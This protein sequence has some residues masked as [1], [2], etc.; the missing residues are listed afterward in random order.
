MRETNFKKRTP[1]SF[2]WEGG[3]R[4][5]CTLPLDPPLQGEE[6]LGAHFA[7]SKHERVPKIVERF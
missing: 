2:I 5:P 4:T 6:K 3:V 1:R 7:V